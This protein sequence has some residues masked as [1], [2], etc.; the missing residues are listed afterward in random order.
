M[1]DNHRAENQLRV[2]AL[3]R[4]NWLFASSSKGAARGIAIFARPEPPADRDPAASL[5]QR[6]PDARGHQPAAVGWPAHAERRGRTF[7]Y[8]DPAYLPCAGHDVASATRPDETNAEGAREFRCSARTG[9]TKSLK[10]TS[11]TRTES[12][13][14][15]SECSRWSKRGWPCSLQARCSG[16]LSVSNRTRDSREFRRMAYCFGARTC[17]SLVQTVSSVSRIKAIHGAAAR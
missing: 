2:V 15:V 16:R 13:I 3:D 10:K 12:R 4:K 1:I 14:S 6:R 11:L 5:S 17:P 8:Q 7:R 9:S